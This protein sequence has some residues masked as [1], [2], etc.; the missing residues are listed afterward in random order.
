MIPAVNDTMDGTAKRFEHNDIIPARMD[1][2]SDVATAGSVFLVV[3]YSDHNGTQVFAEKDAEGKVALP[4]VQMFNETGTIGEGIYANRRF[5][6]TTARIGARR[7]LLSS[8]LP[9]SR[10]GTQFCN[11]DWSV[12]G[13]PIFD[14]ELKDWLKAK[15]TR[16]EYIKL[17]Q[18]QVAVLVDKLNYYIVKMGSCV[19]M[20]VMDHRERVLADLYDVIADLEGKKPKTVTIYSASGPT[21]QELGI[22]FTNMMVRKGEIGRKQNGTQFMLERM[23]TLQSVCVDSFMGEEREKLTSFRSRFVCLDPINV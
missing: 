12:N 16:V 18:E 13:Q 7:Y 3:C 1:I 20:G 11:I 2:H 15:D 23:W 17:R 14:Q 22:Q 19:V 4:R 5:T 21:E 6:G 10:S 9:N 8:V